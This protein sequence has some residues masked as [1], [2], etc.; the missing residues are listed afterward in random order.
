MAVSPT[1]AEICGYWVQNC[2]LEVQWPFTTA[3]VRRASYLFRPFE[4]QTSGCAAMRIYTLDLC[5][6]DVHG[7]EKHHG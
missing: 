7:L 6:C 2:T 5:S 4:L 1:D 3:P